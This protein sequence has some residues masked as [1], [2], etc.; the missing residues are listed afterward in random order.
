MRWFVLAAVLCGFAAF[1]GSAIAAQPENWGIGLQTSA[2]EIKDM[3]EAFHDEL[4]V[5]VTGITL[6]VMLLL[7]YVVIRFRASANPTPSKRTHHT[8]IEIAWTVVPVLILMFI[9][10][11]SFKLLYAQDRIPDAEL[12]VRVTGNQWNWTYGYDHPENGA[13]EYTSLPL[14]DEEAEERGVPRLLST[15]VPMVLPVGTTVR[16]IVTASDV[17]HS[18][19]VPS[20]G[21]KVDAVP[22]RAN[23][24][25]TRVR[26]VGTYYGQCSE[27]CGTAHYNMATMVEVVSK[28]EFAAWLD[29]AYEEYAAAPAPA[30]PVRLADAGRAR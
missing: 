6:F 1:G 29:R 5:I 3:I 25:W 23:E 26:E 22:G 8:L 16:F 11:D 18:F 27:L 14:T 9:A 2:T 24:T 12:T 30:Q 10:I 15:D 7:L 20:F 19:T 13:F 4:L 17:L 21:F 28:E